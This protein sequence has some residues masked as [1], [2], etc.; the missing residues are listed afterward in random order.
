MLPNEGRRSRSDQSDLGPTSPTLVGQKI[1]SFIVKALY[2]QSSGRTTNCQIEVLFK[3]S[4][5]CSPPSATREIISFKSLLMEASSGQIYLIN[6]LPCIFHFM[7]FVFNSIVERIN[8]MTCISN[9]VICPINFVLHAFN[10]VACGINFM[11]DI[12]NFV[13]HLI[14]IMTCV[15]SF[16][17]C[18]E[19]ISSHVH[20]ILRACIM[21][22]LCVSNFRAYIVYNMTCIFHLQYVCT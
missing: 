19:S 16:M 1:L 7:S 8:F 6:I 9:F 10:Y 18:A 13:T 14:N 15:F 12:F 5:Q 20:F 3:W 11:P 21:Y 17:A 4:D 22:T 2:F